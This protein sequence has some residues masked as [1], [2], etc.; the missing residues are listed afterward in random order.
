MTAPLDRG[1]LPPGISRART[2]PPIAEM[3][4]ARASTAPQA[5][6]RFESQDLTASTVTQPHRGGQAPGRRRGPS[7]V[8]KRT[9]AGVRHGDDGTRVYRAGTWKPDFAH[10]AITFSVR[11]LAISG[12][13]G[14]FKRFDVTVIAPE[15]PAGLTVEATIDVVSVDTH[16]K[17][18]DRFLRISD[19]FDVSRHPTWIFR[20]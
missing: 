20:S 18:R 14:S 13:R 1:G 16:V 15:D 8:G 2:Q 12:V 3:W 11:P 17:D 6:D 4:G 19:F 10:S 5:R 9:L 7:A